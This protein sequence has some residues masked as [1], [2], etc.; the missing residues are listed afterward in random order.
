MVPLES[1]WVPILVS[2][3]L[4]FIASSISHSVLRFHRWDYRGLPSM[5]TDVMEVLRRT[6]VSPG[7]YLFPYAPAKEMSAPGFQEKWK[8][9]PIGL[10]T[11]MPARGHGMARNLML[12]FLYCIAV[13]A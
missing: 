13:A 11:L 12:W 1:L 8:R 5:E 3:V 4:V 10:L 6:A 9:G 2:G 7:D